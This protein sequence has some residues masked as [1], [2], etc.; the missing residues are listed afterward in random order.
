MVPDIRQPI[1]HYLNICINEIRLEN[2]LAILNG[3]E[4]ISAYGNSV[5]VEYE[6]CVRLLF[7]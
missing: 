3:I 7:R 4:K 5:A 1:S 2:F 6:L